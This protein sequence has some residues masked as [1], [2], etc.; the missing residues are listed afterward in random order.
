ML[1]KSQ[2]YFF[3][4]FL[5]IIGALA[6]FIALPYLQAIVLAAAL[7][8]VCYHPYEWMVR[9]VKYRSLAALLMILLVILIIFIPLSV[10]GF[11]A[12]KEATGL[13]NH[14]STDSLQNLQSNP[15]IARFLGKFSP[16][17]LEH[18]QDIL[19]GILDWLIASA[20]Y[21]FS[22]TIGIFLNA[23]LCVFAL[24]Y[25]LKDGRRLRDWLIAFTP[26]PARYD[27]LIMDRLG[28]TVNS[29]VRGYL[30]VGL[31]HGLAAGIGLTIF[32]VPNATLWGIIV[33]IA[34][35]IPAVGATTVYLPSII[36]LF[37][38]GHPGA[39]AGLWAWW[40]AMIMLID[41]ILTPRL[42]SR[43]ARIHP[44]A[45]FVAVLG[46]IGFFGP[47]GFLIG[48]LVFSLFFALL[49][50]Y[51]EFHKSDEVKPAAAVKTK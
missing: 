49:D 48:P 31:I 44:F 5:I 18:P 47:I 28:N 29:V 6:F 25:F 35:L 3:F 8:V 50:I 32:G 24:F 34:A 46:G 33:A 40:L 45:V 16:Q 15:V 23:V 17:T 4:G 21:F 20:G 11:Q 9:K 12:F 7:A 36:Y 22:S 27:V 38:Q 13:Y 19:K 10:V 42:V 39:A 2:L 43:G 41:N 51:V 37:L 26:L 14:L 1:E 30:V